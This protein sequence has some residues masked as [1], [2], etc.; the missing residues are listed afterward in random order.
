[1]KIL[2]I[3]DEERLS[4]AVTQVLKKNQYLVDAVFDGEDGL[5]YALT[6]IYD[7]IILD[8]MLPKRDGIEILKELR[9]RN[10]KTPVIMLTAKGEIKDKI[11]GLD[12]GAD[13]YLTKPFVMGELLARLRALGRRPENLLETDGVSVGD[14]ELNS[15][16]ML[17]RHMQES[18]K[19][20]AKEFQVIYSG[21]RGQEYRRWNT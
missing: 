10:I 5:D 13:D 14:V 7:I 11:L 17:L 3:E 6:G 16:T 20:T 9:K 4:E 12:S 18:V 15:D 21:I 2:I 1:M 19:L 8:I